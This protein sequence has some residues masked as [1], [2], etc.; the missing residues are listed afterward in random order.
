MMRKGSSRLTGPT[1]P[2]V[3]ETP[4]EDCLTTDQDPLTWFPFQ[5]TRYI[6][7]VTPDLAQ[8]P[9]VFI[10][11]DLFDRRLERIGKT[12]EQLCFA[13]ART[14]NESARAWG[15]GRETEQ[16]SRVCERTRLK[17]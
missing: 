12:G 10:W 6:C 17:R 14:E 5:H 16:M 7:S 11:R 3:V 1:D 4:Q 13:L 2:N 8:G 15:R 9:G